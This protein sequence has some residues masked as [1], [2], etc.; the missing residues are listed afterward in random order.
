MAPCFPKAFLRSSLVRQVVVVSLPSCSFL[1][2]GKITDS[3]ASRL[4]RGKQEMLQFILL[5]GLFTQSTIRGNLNFTQLSLVLLRM[6][7]VYARNHYQYSWQ[8]RC[9]LGS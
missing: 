3:D 2:F 7:C 4:L 1:S 8:E 6:F 5:L 9:W